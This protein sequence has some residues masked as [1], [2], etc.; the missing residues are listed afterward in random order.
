MVSVS[1]VY[2]IKYTHIV[3]YQINYNI[4]F[5]AVLPHIQLFSHVYLFLNVC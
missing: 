3:E 5:H 1:D 2:S 4:Y